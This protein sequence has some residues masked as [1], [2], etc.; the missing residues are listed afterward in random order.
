MHKNISGDLV[1]FGKAN[2]ASQIIPDKKV[3]KCKLCKRKMSDYNNNEF[4]FA[5][6]YIGLHEEEDRAAK[7]K[8]DEIRRKMKEPKKPDPEIWCHN[9]F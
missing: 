3:R 9:D 7:V 4:C 6:L 1:Y 8:C 5:H 2:E